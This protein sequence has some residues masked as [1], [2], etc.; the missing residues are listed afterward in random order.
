MTFIEAF[1]LGIVQGVTEFLP[2]SSSSHLQIAKALLHLRDETLY[3]D[4]SCHF[5]TLLALGYFFRKNIALLFTSE[6]NRLPLFFLSLIPLVPLYFLFKPLRLMI[7]GT[8]LS[9]LFLFITALLLFASEKIR[10]KKKPAETTSG[11]AVESLSIG[12]MQ[13]LS[14][15]PGISRSA[16]TISSARFLSWS[17]K[18]AVQYSFLLSIPTVLGG[19]LLE[20]VQLY[21]SK[22]QFS[23]TDLFS[24]LVGFFTSLTFGLLIVKLF[25]NRL[26]QGN[27]TPFAWYCCAMAALAVYLL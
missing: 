22:T 19:N 16:S 18:E 9:G 27:L 2:V 13:G 12:I 25:I 5:G 11:K 26:A 21:F 24:C 20:L 15:I 4:L 3:F 14:L 23:S 8:A 7:S 10:I 17:P 6:R 1:I